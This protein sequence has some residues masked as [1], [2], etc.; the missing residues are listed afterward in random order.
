[1]GRP[2]GAGAPGGAGGTAGAGGI[3]GLGGNTQVSSALTT[4]LRDGAAGDRWA[5][6]T[7]SSDSA[8]PLQLASGE[9]VMSIGGF[10]GTD[11]VPTLAQFERY[12]AEHEIHYF[13]GA[14]ADSFGGGSAT[15]RRSPPG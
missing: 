9:P 5:A 3:G 7:V 1:M 8:A 11:P 2:G 13:V 4:L 10:N 15:P 12:V 6:A 14:N